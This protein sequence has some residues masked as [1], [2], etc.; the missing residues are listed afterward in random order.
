MEM[1]EV[2]ST[3]T[4]SVRIMR[5]HQVQMPCLSKCLYMVSAI[6]Q[7]VC[8]HDT[9]L[10]ITFFSAHHS[11][12][13][14]NRNARELV[15]GTVRLNSALPMRMKNQILPVTLRSSGTAYA[16]LLKTPTTAY[17]MPST[18]F[19]SHELSGSDSEGR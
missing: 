3:M 12:S 19:L 14:V 6:V 4:C 1:M 7:L 8:I 9:P 11:P 15:I 16:G 2:D 5:Y 17:H 13:T 10:L 18:F